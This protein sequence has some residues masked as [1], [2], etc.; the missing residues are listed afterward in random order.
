MARKNF[1]LN[2]DMIT[3]DPSDLVFAY[4][5][6]KNRQVNDAKPWKSE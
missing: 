1:E 5:A 6:Q 4:D 3:L 2:N